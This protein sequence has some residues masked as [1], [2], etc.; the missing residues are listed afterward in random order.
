L[1]EDIINAIL[2][3]RDTLAL[4]PTGGG[5]SICFQVPAMMKEGICLVITPLIALMRD[6]VDNLER[7][8]IKAVAIYAGL[9]NR[10]VEALLE[11]ARRGHYKFLYVSPERLQSRR[12]LDYCDGMPVN[13]LAVDEAHCISQWGYDF[14]P[15]YL[16]IATIREYF[17]RVP[18]LA[19]TAT[20]TPLVQG[21]ICKQ[22]L[23]QQPQVFSKSFARANLSY[24]VLEE[25]SRPE[26]L[27]HI[28][29]RVPGSAI[30]Y[31]RNRKRTR[32]LADMLRSRNIRADYYHA[33][34]PPNERTARQE[35]WIN[36]ETRV[37]VCTNAFGMGIDKPDVRVVVHYD[38]PDSLE[39]Y[40]QEA[41]RAGRDEQKAYAALLYDEQELLDMEG[42][43]PLQ[44]PALQEIKHIYQCI[45]NYLQVPVASAEGLYFNFDI[46]DFV[47]HFQLN[48]TI[49]YSAIRILEQEGILQLS[50]SVY[51]PSRAGFITNKETLYAV[52]DAQPEL[53]PLIK[54]LLR[55]YEGI[56]D[57]EVRIF[58]KQLS[59]I[60]RRPEA[61]VSEQL[62]QL[63]QRGIIHYKPKRDEPQLC[64]LQER[65]QAQNLRI[66]MARVEER[67]RAYTERL[68]AMFA[69]IRNTQ[70]CRTQS[71]VTYFGE[72]DTSACGIC[73]V[74]AKRKQGA[75]NEAAVDDI[76]AAI[77]RHLQ[78]PAH[79]TSLL[80][81][82][83]GI[84]EERLMEVL[85]FLISEEKI[86]RDKD[87]ILRMY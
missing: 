16:Q 80:Q 14:R 59:R 65:L 28:L 15:A 46:N 11:N 34:L 2:E 82:L 71:L 17:P 25:S 6:Q 87:G 4:M 9:T 76:A 7:R 22:L 64:F 84:P 83:P 13:L 62:L 38:V 41:G 24:S 74:C 44:F 53:E 58:E 43:I 40:Y 26:K 36:N 21:D 85:Q 18:V 30:V 42:R 54:A 35:A 3:G 51:L 72:K 79:V 8:G 67:K 37:I 45:V 63:H 70:A 86:V 73:D 39:A 68:Q 5:K 52:E 81:H 77:I 33:G 32:E 27:V 56:F 47:K 55:N 57:N 31:C 78:Q 10:E 29:N 50:E 12:F 20:A 61:Q 75:L 60:L 1:Q 49:T 23:M 66:N 19:L 48:I 69:Y